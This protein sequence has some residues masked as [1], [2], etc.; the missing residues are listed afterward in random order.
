MTRKKCQ[1]LQFESVDEIK[2]IPKEF[3]NIYMHSINATN[4]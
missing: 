2:Y 1:I 4:K 3:L